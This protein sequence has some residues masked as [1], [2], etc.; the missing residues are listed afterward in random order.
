MRYWWINQNQTYQEEVSGEYIWCPKIRS[1]GSKSQFYDN[2]LEVS[3]GD[4]LFSY[5]SMQISAVGI[6]ISHACSAPDPSGR[7]GI[8][9]EGWLIAVKYV[10]LL[11]RIRP[12]NHID[13][14]R[15]KLPEKYSPI[16]RDGNG[17]QGVYL[18]AMPRP[19]ALALIELLGSEYHAAL[20]RLDDGLQQANSADRDN[21]LK[22][23][24]FESVKKSSES[25]IYPHLPHSGK[26][27]ILT[28]VNG[29]GKTRYLA[30]LALDTLEYSHA[31]PRRF[32]R[33]ICLSGTIYEKFPSKRNITTETEQYIYLGNRTNN[34]MFSEIAP[35]R[36][37]LPHLLCVEHINSERPIQAGRIL[38]SIGFEPTLKIKFRRNS[39]NPAS[40]SRH[41]ELDLPITLLE[42]SPGNVNSAIR[43]NEFVH[44][45]FDF[46]GISFV[47][48]DISYELDELSSGERLYILSTLA[49]CFCAV[50]NS[51]I[52]FD[53]PE[54]SL[55]PKWQTKLIRDLYTIVTSLRIKTTIVVA[56][57]SP[58]VASSAPNRD[59]LIGTLPSTQPWTASRLYGKNSDSI[60][61]QQFGLFS[62]RA[63]AVTTAIQQCLRALVLIQRND[64][65]FI[66]AA[67][68]L[69]Q[70]EI[71]ID[72]ADP[73][74]STVREILKI[75][76]GL[77]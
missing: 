42:S 63:L 76:E 38:E 7:S 73:I 43:Y 13:Q 28:G 53:E 5:R 64:R 47:K 11:N 66:I 25:A 39:N 65:P 10:E 29:T 62:P 34:N 20:D 67:E 56:T 14:L 77:Q 26:F 32:E 55:H 16:S 6:A 2:M 37:V 21:S 31:D 70:M 71:N 44:S 58:L 36:Q 18:A 22:I 30:K 15:S 52:L 51:L 40:G 48:S 17:L 57:H 59:S 75:R 60:L 12:K 23:Q 46:I 27:H 72:P 24:D 8:N 68:Q 3:K 1:N 33:L 41:S 9:S 54:N 61:E 35:F 50:E 45:E 74:Y 4:I 19:F 69:A 49:L